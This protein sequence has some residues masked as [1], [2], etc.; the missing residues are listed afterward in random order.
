MISK[1]DTKTKHSISGMIIFN[2]IFKS[3]FPLHPRLYLN[4]NESKLKQLTLLSNEKVEGLNFR[5]N[6]IY[7]NELMVFSAL[8]NFS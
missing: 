5:N 3:L 6:K 2:L 8:F 4:K 7:S 1:H